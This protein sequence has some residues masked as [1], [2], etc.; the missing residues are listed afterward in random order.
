MLGCLAILTP[1][2]AANDLEERGYLGLWRGEYNC[3]GW[4]FGVDL[5]FAKDRISGETGLTWTFYPLTVESSIQMGSFIGTVVPNDSPNGASMTPIDWIERPSGYSMVS[6]EFTLSSDDQLTGQIDF[7]GCDELVAQRIE[8]PEVIGIAGDDALDVAFLNSLT[9]RWRGGFTCAE[10]RFVAELVLP[11]FASEDVAGTMLYKK[12]EQFDTVTN[13]TIG[14]V[15]DGNKDEIDVRVLERHSYKQN[16]QTY[17][18]RSIKTDADPDTL[19]VLL[20][21]PSCSPTILQRDDPV[22]PVAIL[23]VAATPSQKTLFAPDVRADGRIHLAPTRAACDAL[24]GWRAQ[25]TDADARLQRAGTYVT[26]WGAWPTLFADSKFVPFFGI[27]YS[28]IAET[29]QIAGLIVQRLMRKECR[30]LGIQIELDPLVVN[31]AFGVKRTGFGTKFHTFQL[32]VADMMQDAGALQ[33]LTEE[34]AQVS[35][36]AA[37]LT[38]L[39]R[40]ESQLQ[41]L[42][43]LSEADGIQITETIRERR[44]EITTSMDDAFLQ[45]LG[46]DGST[47]T[48]ADAVKADRIAMARGGAEKDRITKLIN[49]RLMAIV[50]AEIIAASQALN[51]AELVAFTD[52]QRKRFEPLERYRVVSDSFAMLQQR[53]ATDIKQRLAEIKETIAA[54][55]EIAD[56]PASYS[57]VSTFTQSHRTPSLSQDAWST[58][59]TKAMMLLKSA[60]SKLPHRETTRP[61]RPTSSGAMA[62]LHRNADITAFLRGDKLAAYQAPRQSTLVYLAELSSVFRTYCPAALPPGISTL[63]ASKFMNL[64]ALTGDRD[65]MAREGW[66]AIAEGLQI[67]AN[68]GAAMQTAMNRDEIRASATSDAQILLNALPCTGPEL[69]EMF[70]NIADWIKDPA[71]GIAKQDKNLFDVC[72]D[73]VGNGLIMRETREY[74]GC[75]SDR[76]QR[77]AKTGFERYLRASPQTHWRQISFLDRGLNQLLLACRR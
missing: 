4:E 75:A 64:N 36:D 71:V 65:A 77:S 27:P 33:E 52:R 35:S 63:I 46:T 73:A 6:T 51:G 43:N 37:G 72:L 26:N 42:A 25:I 70:S 49:D 31:T 15:L 57:A 14:F 53:I 11:Q 69:R 29:P 45:A 2:A 9:G 40:I 61:E 30:Q 55:A 60:V 74:C 19:T 16:Q 59:D 76:I 38:E 23:P 1:F 17:V 48:L 41:Q 18:P 22:G 44:A 28:K 8:S 32:A 13:Q 54:A 66:K 58:Y 67:L 24:S 21:E 12:R 10:T 34:I 39:V 47:M 7:R 20:D 5:E 56:L 62:G 50:D 3:N 68:P